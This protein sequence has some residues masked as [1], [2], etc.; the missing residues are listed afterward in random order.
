MES[1]IKPKVLKT[2]NLLTKE[3]IKL[4]KYQNEKLK[5]VLNL[6][7]FLQQRKKVMKKLLT[8]Y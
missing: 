8:A 2:V 3:Y 7:H 4:I 6:K 1:E 5:C